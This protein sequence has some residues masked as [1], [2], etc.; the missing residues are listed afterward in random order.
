M[1]INLPYHFVFYLHTTL[2]LS[3][4]GCLSL[5][6]SLGQTIIIDRYVWLFW[7]ASTYHLPLTRHFL[8]YGPTRTD[9]TWSVITVNIWALLFN[10]YICHLLN[11]AFHFAEAA[12]PVEVESVLNIVRSEVTAVVDD[13]LHVQQDINEVTVRLAEE[14]DGRENTE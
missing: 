6:P 8:F 9:H 10:R 12:L 2:A 1:T 3:A 14:Q 7:L 4:L 5:L 11:E 13:Q